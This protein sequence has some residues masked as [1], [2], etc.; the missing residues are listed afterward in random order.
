MPPPPRNDR[1][2]SPPEGLSS[3]ILS[4]APAADCCFSG[5][6]LPIYPGPFAPVSRLAILMRKAAT[7]GDEEKRRKR[8]G[9]WGQKLAPFQALLKLI[10][11]QEKQVAGG[12]RG[13][14]Q[15]TVRYVKNWE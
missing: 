14:R 4:F 13:V 1:G 5:P 9:I 3:L 8:I 15:Q 7:G 6:H 12:S 2:A 11:R 10:K